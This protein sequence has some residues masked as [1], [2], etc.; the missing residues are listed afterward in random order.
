MRAL[1][2]AVIVGLVLFYGG[3]AIAADE[4]GDW[5]AETFDVGGRVEIRR[6]NSSTWSPLTIGVAVCLG[7]SVRTHPYSRAGIRL[8]DETP[9]RLNEETTATFHPDPQKRTLL[10]LLRGL[11]GLTSRDP[12]SLSISTPMV[13]AGLEGTEFTVEVTDSEVVFSVYEGVVALDNE[14]VSLDVATGERATI[15]AAGAAPVAELTDRSGLLWALYYPP[16]LDGPVPASDEEPGDGDRSAAF[17]SGRAQSRL[18]V[19]QIDD[20]REDLAAALALDPGYPDAL[21]L[22]AMIAEAEDDRPRAEGAIAAALAR[23]PAAPGALIAETYL[24]MADDSLRA[25]LDAAERAVAAAPGNAIARARLGDVLLALDNAREARSVATEALAIDPDL[26]AAHGVLGFAA[27]AEDEFETA[28]AH[29]E[30]ALARDSAVVVP[31]LGLAVALKRSGRERESRD[32]FEAALALDLNSSV[33]RSYMGKAYVDEFRDELAFVQFDLASEIDEND[34]TPLIHGAIAR[35]QDNQSVRAYQDVSEALARSATGASLRSRLL[36]DEDSVTRATGFGRIHWALGFEEQGR[37]RGTHAVTLDPADHTAHRLVADSLANTSRFHAARVSENYQ[38]RMLQPLSVLPFPPQL[39]LVNTSIADSLGPAALL[40]S[41]PRSAF[42]RNGVDVQASGVRGGNGTAGENVV[43]SGLADGK[44]WNLGA[45]RFETDGFRPNGDFAH[46]VLDAFVQTRLSSAT[47][48]QF[49]LRSGKTDKGIIN[50]LYDPENYDTRIRQTIEVDSARV[51]A[52]HR[53]GSF[54]TILASLTFEEGTSGFSVTIPA[55]TGVFLRDGVRL[56]LQFQNEL[57]RWS[58]VSGLDAMRM[59]RDESTT[60]SLPIPMPPPAT[61]SVEEHTTRFVNPYLYAT[62]RVGDSL[63]L[64]AGAALAH[65]DGSGLSDDETNAKLGLTWRPLPETYVRAAYFEILQ[66]PYASKQLISPSLEP[67]QVAGFPQQVYG[68]G[69][70][71]SRT[72]G[73]GFDHALS[74]RLRIGVEWYE[75]SADI[76]VFIG[77]PPNPVRGDIDL[78]ESTAGFRVYWTPTSRL[79]VGSGWEYEDYDTH[80]VDSP[81]NFDWLRTNRLPVKTTLFIGRSLS[82]KLSGTHILQ[83]G[84]VEVADPAAGFVRADS[85]FW[86]FDGAFDVRLPNRRGSI[87]LGI[88]NLL[89]EEF[90][91]Q[92]TDPENPHVFPERLGYARFTLTF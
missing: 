51:G 19:G 63:F 11:I 50:V 48:L 59:H 46:E 81:L 40:Q 4:C 37:V 28:I 82:L 33:V 14:T 91:F 3:T 88:R 92:D 67:T 24:R 20:A 34:P 26:A 78:R 54:S 72:Y 1:P 45:F 49:E 83:E 66:A 42:A 27:M 6:A 90:L 25:A 15:G 85:E 36:Q 38:A 44:S 7:D 77:P 16:I 41:E 17:F 30:D 13:N 75:R 18:A 89:D 35:Q 39:A 61:T 29:F 9:V 68:V 8:P 56:D 74:A 84:A 43:V 87:E 65:F 23:D 32:Q 70:E 31:R 12:L 5:A 53:L 52:M 22:E 86:I 57:P 21:A 2:E 76:P 58:I 55:I 64:T 10:E 69:G 47:S 60:I 62:R 79:A 71:R 73:L 80:G